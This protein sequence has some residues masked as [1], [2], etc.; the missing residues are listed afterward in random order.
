MQ[1]WNNGDKAS[2]VKQAIEQNFNILSKNLSHNMLA[3]SSMERIA[4][5]DAYLCEG[6]IVFDTTLKKWFIYH[7]GSWN[8]YSF[9]TTNYVKN[10]STTTWI[11]NEISIPYSQHKILNPVAQLYILEN[12]VYSPVIGG[13]CVDENS[14]VTISADVPFDGKVVIK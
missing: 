12:N 7:N 11:N 3:L 4:L 14:N 2:V 1:T 6:L 8:D 10:I 5:E 13:V 9:E